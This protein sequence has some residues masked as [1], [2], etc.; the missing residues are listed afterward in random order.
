MNMNVYDINDTFP[1]R[2]GWKYKGETVFEVLQK[3]SG[4]IKDLIRLHPT[5]C[6]SEECMAEAQQITKGFYDERVKPKHI[7]PKNIFE[8]LRTYRTPYKFDFNNDEIV[9]LNR[10]KLSND[11]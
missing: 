2:R 1:L 4:Y 11:D 7:P 3:D 6:L 10:S 5:F 8:G 9:R